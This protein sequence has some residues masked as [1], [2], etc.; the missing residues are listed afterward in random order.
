VTGVRGLLRGGEI[1]AALEALR[2]GA[3]WEQKSNEG[4]G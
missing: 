1:D 3:G 4:N 2:E